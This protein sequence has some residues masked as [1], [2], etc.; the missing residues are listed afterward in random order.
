[1]SS[2]GDF[3]MYGQL[4]E[5][6]LRLAREPQNIGFMENPSGKGSAVGKCGDSVEVFLQITG[7]IISDISS[8]TGLHLYLGLCERDERT[9]ERQEPGRRSQS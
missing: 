9:G 7:D 6:F 4:G 3:P 2:N 1:M 8:T 5:H